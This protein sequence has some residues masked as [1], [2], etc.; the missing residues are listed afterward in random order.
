MT[1]G[2]CELQMFVLR[3]RA[4]PWARRFAR[5]R[6]R[7]LPCHSLTIHCHKGDTE[8][9]LH[10][11]STAESRH[12]STGTVEWGSPSARC[13]ARAGSRLR[14]PRWQQERPRAGSGSR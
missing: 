12:F 3:E 8:Q 13:A 9:F 11:G 4:V 14:H 5:S 7:M 6:A 1:E 10:I 2:Y